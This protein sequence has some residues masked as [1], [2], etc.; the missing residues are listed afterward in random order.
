MIPHIH[1]AELGEARSK[2]REDLHSLKLDFS[3]MR[4]SRE[5]EHGRGKGPNLARSNHPSGAGPRVQPTQTAGIRGSRHLCTLV[6]SS[7]SGETL[8]EGWQEP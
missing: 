3:N 4:K 5:C 8:V 7:V 1:N 6:F 2:A